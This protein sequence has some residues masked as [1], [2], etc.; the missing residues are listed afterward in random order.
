MAGK[1]QVHRI[2]TAYNLGRLM[3][4]LNQL[5]RCYV[6]NLSGNVIFLKDIK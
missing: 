4:T 3:Q 6:I 1:V 2:A 5:K